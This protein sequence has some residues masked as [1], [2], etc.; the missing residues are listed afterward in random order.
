MPEYVG[1]P[2]KDWN[3][4]EKDLK[5][6]LDPFTPG[7]LEAAKKNALSALKVQQ[8]EGRVIAQQCIGGYMFL[9]SMIGPLEVL[10]MFYD[11]PELIH[12]CMKTWFTLA[13]TIIAEHQK[14]V[15]FDEFMFTE[16]ICYNHGSLISHDM[17]REF[18]FPYYQQLVDNMKKRNNGR[19]IRIKLD[20]DGWVDSV[21]DLYGEVGVDYFSPFEVASNCD[22]LKVAREHPNILLDGGIDKRIIAVGGDALRR[23]ID[24]IVPPLRKRGGYTPT[25]DHSVP[26]EVSFENYMLFRS[27][28]KEYG[29]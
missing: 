25:C 11:E 5:W 15:A 4:W 3:T 17:V 18:L 27:L 29:E 24:T 10:Y 20:S 8:E 13:D 23:H 16:D 14:H 19:R 6:R 2:L 7:R 26:A 9:R 22:I 28:L 21:I 1:H 12:D